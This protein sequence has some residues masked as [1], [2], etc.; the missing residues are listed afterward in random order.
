VSQHLKVLK[1][2]GLVVSR[3][4]GNRRVYS[5]DP[6]GV[7]A[8]RAWLDGVWEHALA[9]FHKFAEQAVADEVASTEHPDKEQP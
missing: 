1:D 2:G 6:D 9:S 3:A 4:Q 8:M 5:L 7:A